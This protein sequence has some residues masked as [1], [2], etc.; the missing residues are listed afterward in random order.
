MTLAANNSYAGTTTV[1]AS[2]I[3]N[4]GAGGAAGTLGA[5][6]TTD[7]GTLTFNRTG[8]YSYGGV[9]SGSG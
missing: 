6:N 9:I 5:G 4:V 2:S 3:V 8:S 7:N 1:G